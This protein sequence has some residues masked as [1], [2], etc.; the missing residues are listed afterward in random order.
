MKAQIQLVI[1]EIEGQFAPRKKI[2]LP[3][4]YFEEFK[5]TKSYKSGQNFYNTIKMSNSYAEAKQ[6]NLA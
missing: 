1:K 2:I 3:K 6:H 5:Q 4:S